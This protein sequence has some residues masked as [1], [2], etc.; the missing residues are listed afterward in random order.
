MYM[1][2]QECH[3]KIEDINTLLL[4]KTDRQKA[5]IY[6]KVYKMVS[7]LLKESR[8]GKQLDKLE[9]MML[10][11]YFKS[12]IRKR[13]TTEERAKGLHELLRII[14][15]ET[16]FGDLTYTSSY[17]CKQIEYMTR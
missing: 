13:T 6:Y 11:K 14:Q 9:L 1:D 17:L 15:I 5:E 3:N 12:E 10:N 16:E 4:V 2:I 8:K 7:R